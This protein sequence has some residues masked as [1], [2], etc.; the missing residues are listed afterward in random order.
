MADDRPRVRISRTM[1]TFDPGVGHRKTPDL[2]PETRPREDLG[3]VLKFGILGKGDIQVPPF[4]DQGDDTGAVAHKH[5]S[6]DGQG[7]DVVI[8]PDIEILLVEK[9]IG[10]PMELSIGF[11]KENVFSGVLRQA[12]EQCFRL[13]P[14][15]LPATAPLGFLKKVAFNP[16]RTG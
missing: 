7:T 9:D 8:D 5:G 15:M 2:K 16:E 4:A 3:K 6:A 1:E 10:A 12:S 13:H 11:Y 14:A